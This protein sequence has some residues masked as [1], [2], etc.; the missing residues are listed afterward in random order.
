MIGLGQV[1]HLGE[2]TSPVAP[3]VAVQVPQPE[4]PPAGDIA[5]AA[6]TPE[7]AHTWA[8]L[9]SGDH[10][11]KAHSEEAR[12]KSRVEELH[13]LVKNKSDDRRNRVLGKP[14]RP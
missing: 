6:T 13:R 4:D 5:L 7:E 12:R 9:K 11:E 3:S 10:L 8:E 1:P 2:T 14:A